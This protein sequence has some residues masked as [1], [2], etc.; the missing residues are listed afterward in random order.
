MSF[1]K[2]KFA[3]VRNVK[4][5]PSKSGRVL[6]RN[7]GVEDNEKECKDEDLPWALPL[8]SNLSASTSGIG[9][10]PHGLEI[11]SRVLVGYMP[12][13]TAEQFPIILGSFQRSELP[14]SFG[15]NTGD[16]PQTGGSPKSIAPD[17]PY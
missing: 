12:E 8:Q 5:D 1:L 10:I 13:D 11:G 9:D 14:E 16:D 4:D 17:R 3:E 7:Y 15:P 2:V 6:I